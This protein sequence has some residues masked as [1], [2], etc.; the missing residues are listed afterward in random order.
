MF[1]CTWHSLMSCQTPFAMYLFALQ[2]SNSKVIKSYYKMPCVYSIHSATV[3]VHCNHISILSTN[4]VFSVEFPCFLAR[5]YVTASGVST[6]CDQILFWRKTRQ[7][8][9]VFVTSVW[10][11]GLWLISCLLVEF[12]I[13]ITKRLWNISRMFI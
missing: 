3:I 7:Y 2:I 5:K 6:R 11:Y 9:T 1:D 4:F 8:K 12:V 10:F 13:L